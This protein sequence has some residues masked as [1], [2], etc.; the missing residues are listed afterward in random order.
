MQYICIYMHIIHT[1]VNIYT[2]AYYALAVLPRAF[3]HKR[4][5][6]P[7]HR[8]MTQ[9]P[10][11]PCIFIGY[12]P[13]ARSASQESRR[14]RHRSPAASHGVRFRRPFLNDIGTETFRD[15]PCGCRLLSADIAT[16]CVERIT[17]G[18]IQRNTPFRAIFFYFFFLPVARA[19]R[20]SPRSASAFWLDILC[21]SSTRG[22][23]RRGLYVRAVCTGFRRRLGR[24]VCAVCL[25]KTFYRII[26]RRW[27]S[28]T[29]NGYSRFAE[30]ILYRTRLREASVKL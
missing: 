9:P 14:R 29:N 10:P 6:A 25:T 8:T 19:A 22:I 27:S 11:H 3:A 16:R 20:F 30:M 5:L 21:C 17:R 28:P 2:Y 7:A 23:V 12:P 13:N 18:K 1:P 15:S 26:C 24:S 4:A